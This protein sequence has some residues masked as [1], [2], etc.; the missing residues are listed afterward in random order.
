MS[1]FNDPKLKTIITRELELSAK[2]DDYTSENKKLVEIE[3]T[4]KKALN[5]KAAA[6]EKVNKEIAEQQ[7][8]IDGL[9]ID[10][11][12]YRN[13]GDYE[14]YRRNKM[15]INEAKE[16]QSII[17][18]RHEKATAEYMPVDKYEEIINTL[19]AEYEKDTKRRANEVMKHISAI[20]RIAQT[21]A[22]DKTIINRMLAKITVEF[23]EDEYKEIRRSFKSDM[24]DRSAACGFSIGDDVLG[25]KTSTTEKVGDLITD[26]RVIKGLRKEIG[27]DN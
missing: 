24:L 23:K 2:A 9:S 18:N 8:I 27:G 12:K 17:K 13:T 19:F 11:E 10:C 26:S 5:E 3:K 7:R 22:L 6:A 4:I 15:R 16:N 21:S 14:A 20:L 25:V 1:F